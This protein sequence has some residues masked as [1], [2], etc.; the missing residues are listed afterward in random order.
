M[1]RYKHSGTLVVLALL[2]LAAVPALAT[3]WTVTSLADDGSAGTL[4]YVLAETAP[5]DTVIFSVTGTITLTQ[6]P[7]FIEQSISINGPGANKLAI[8][9]GYNPFIAPTGASNVFVIQPYDVPVSISGVT[10]ENG[11]DGNHGWRGAA[12]TNNGSLL[13]INN[14]V[15]TGNVDTYGNTAGS[16]IF[17]VCTYITITNST[18]SSNSGGPAIHEELCAT[19]INTAELVTVTNST[20]SNNSSAI[21]AQNPS[22]L[23][24]LTGNTFSGNG[25]VEGRGVVSVGSQNGGGLGAMLFA[26]NN[27]FSGNNGTAI[28]NGGATATIA[29]TT[30]SGNTG[31]AIFTAQS[32]GTGYSVASTTVKNSLLANGALGGNC[33]GVTTTSSNPANSTLISG[34]HNLTDDTTCTAFTQ[35]GDL[36]NPSGGVGL[37]PSGLQNNG[38]PTETIALLASSPAVNAIP[39]PCTDANGNPLTTDQR[40]VTRPQGT[41]CDVGAFELVMIP[42]IIKLVDSYHLPIIT[43]DILTATLTLAEKAPNTTASC[44]D[45]S[46][47]IVEVDLARDFRDLT[48]AQA[49]QLV[50]ETD[51]VRASKGC[52]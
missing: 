50:T 13:T 18:I 21:D 2:V 28:Y 11:Y 1:F 15:I 29:N 30:F 24:T 12:I 16:T 34:G 17:N 40:G 32:L 5:G 33:L 43:Q 25:A 9:G 20:F 6:G 39:V 14:S 36:N 3:T 46:A 4:R 10:I 27:T 19:E 8:N 7:L 38:G 51:Q 48:A 44:L 42:G 23:L 22:P 31:G 41:G 49:S 45:L 35:V 47:F 52:R 26:T 37:S